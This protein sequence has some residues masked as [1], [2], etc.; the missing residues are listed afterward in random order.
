MTFKI[1]NNQSNFQTTK[2]IRSNPEKFEKIINGEV[3][4]NMSAAV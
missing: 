2:L 3:K 4:R 1:L